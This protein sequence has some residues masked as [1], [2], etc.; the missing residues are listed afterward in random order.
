MPLSPLETLKVEEWNQML[1]DNIRGVL[2]GIASA[3]PIMK[4][5][6]GRQVINVFSVGGHQVWPTSAVYCGT[7][8]SHF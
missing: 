7:K 1:E 2:H 8:F 3:L 6:G 4:E 5:Q